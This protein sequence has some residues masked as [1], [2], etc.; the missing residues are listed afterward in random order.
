M[1]LEPTTHG[2]GTLVDLPFFVRIFAPLPLSR[3]RLLRGLG[4]PVVYF[5][6][7]AFSILEALPAKTNMAA[8]FARVGN[9]SP[10]HRTAACLKTW[11]ISTNTNRKV[12]KCFYLRKRCLICLG[13]VYVL[14]DHAQTYDSA[15]SD[16]FFVEWRNSCTE[17][18]HERCKKKI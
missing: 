13:N 6:D 16:I 17:L 11:R 3:L 2:H 5:G 12:N 4:G 7:I 9:G 1:G 18:R 8:L 14:S 15:I 10:F